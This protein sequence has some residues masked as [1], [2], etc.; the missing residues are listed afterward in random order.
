MKDYAKS[1]I[2]FQHQVFAIAQRA[3]QKHRKRSINQYIMEI[4]AG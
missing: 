4:L 3:E 1:S 2:G